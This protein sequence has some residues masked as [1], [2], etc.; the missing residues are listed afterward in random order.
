VRSPAK[1]IKE[2][3]D[4]TGLTHV[5]QKQQECSFSEM[6]KTRKSGCNEVQTYTTALRISK[7]NSFVLYTYIN[8]VRRR[9]REREREREGISFLRAGD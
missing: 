5:W 7:N 8:Y 2:K 3:L 9:E 4:S 6:N 1:K